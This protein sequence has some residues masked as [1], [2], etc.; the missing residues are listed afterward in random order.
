M[1]FSKIKETCIYVN[2]LEGIHD[3]YHI[4][5]EL[6]IISY[7]KGKHLFFRVGKSVLLFFNP[8]ESRLK[9]SPPAHFGSGKQH[10]AFEVPADDYLRVKEKVKA[11]GILV[12]DEI[13]WKSGHESFYFEDPAG[14]ILEV[15]PDKG[16]WDLA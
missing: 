6:P 11:V 4:K 8:D 10:F 14:N 1:N 13:I 5:L 9:N 2:D 15:V 16:I 12:T 3:F 7:L